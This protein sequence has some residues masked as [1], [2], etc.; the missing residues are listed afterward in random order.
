MYYTHYIPVTALSIL[1]V[2]IHLTFTLA[3]IIK[4]RER[5]TER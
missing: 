4:K 3:Q 5:E 1:H 2:C